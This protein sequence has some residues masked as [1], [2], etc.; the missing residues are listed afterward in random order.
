MGPRNQG[1]T[2]ILVLY[3]LIRSDKIIIEQ[4]RRSEELCACSTCNTYPGY[5]SGFRIWG[6][7]VSSWGSSNN[8]YVR[9]QQQQ[10][11]TG[12]PAGALNRGGVWF[13]RNFRSITCYISETVEDRWVCTARHFTSSLE[14]SF[15]PCDIYRDCLRG[16]TRGGQNVQKMW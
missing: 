12:Y 14:F 5:F 7:W 8:F 11:P 15:Q 9:Q 6:V 3:S 10:I 1:R 2:L 13:S 16:V 4:L